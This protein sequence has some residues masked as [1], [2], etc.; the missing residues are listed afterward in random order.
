MTEVCLYLGKNKIAKTTKIKAKNFEK[1][2]HNLTFEKNI[3]QQKCGSK[4]K[5]ENSNVKVKEVL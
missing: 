3:F 4:H 2:V 5:L 1:I